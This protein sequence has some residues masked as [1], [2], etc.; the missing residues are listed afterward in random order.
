M[1]TN[2]CILL[3]LVKDLKS[4]NF[5]FS[6]EKE[7]IPYLIQ[8]TV[9][10]ALPLNCSLIATVLQGSTDQCHKELLA[11]PSRRITAKTPKNFY[12]KVTASLPNQEFLL[13]ITFA[14]LYW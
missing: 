12:G 6:P 2:L 11:N 13:K 10:V 4:N 14:L 1:Y 8:I 7:K 3:Y 5:K 9:Q